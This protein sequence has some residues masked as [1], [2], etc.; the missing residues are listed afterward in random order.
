[1][2]V[3][4]LL[5]LT[6]PESPFSRLVRLSEAERD[7]TPVFA[8]NELTGECAFLRSAAYARPGFTVHSLRRMR[9]TE[10]LLR[11]LELQE[12]GG[13]LAAAAR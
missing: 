2:T 7:R 10:K 9:L 4:L 13:A 8:A 3:D 5:R 1:M 6:D 11:G 12:M